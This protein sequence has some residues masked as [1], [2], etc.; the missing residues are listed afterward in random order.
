MEEKKDKGGDLVDVR[1]GMVVDGGGG[2][3]DAW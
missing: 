3:E 2:F 1:G